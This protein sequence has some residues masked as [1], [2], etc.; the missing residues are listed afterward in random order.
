M[1]ISF[2][3][4]TPKRISATNFV[5][6]GAEMAA[7][8]LGDALALRGH[9]VHYY[10]NCEVSDQ[11]HEYAEFFVAE[12]DRIIAVRASDALFR[13]V[14]C[15]RIVLWSGDAYDQ[16]NN[17]LLN[18][19]M[20]VN[21]LHKVV[22]KSQWQLVSNLEHFPVLAESGKAITM[23]NGV[24]PAHYFA[25][26]TTETQTGFICTS[27]IF[28]GVDRF[29]HIWPEIYK[30]FGMELNLYANISGLYD[31]APERDAAYKREFAALREL[32][33]LNI[34]ATLPQTD[35]IAE[36][37]KHYLMLYPNSDFMESS[38]NSALE[39]MCAGTPVITTEKAGLPETIKL[40]FGKLIPDNL[41]LTEYTKRMIAHIKWFLDND[42]RYSDWNTKRRWKLIDKFAWSKVAE[43]WESEVLS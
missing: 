28:R 10:G 27:R 19:I 26:E 39:S 9:D 7:K 30:E 33:G 31:D 25:P 42:K 24:N 21:R 40:G 36:M 15:E 22:F 6:G 16:P 38:C 2:F 35:I 32:N 37:H 14:K 20:V 5:A 41:P 13:P 4:A 34:K 11:F 23:P 12:H 43:Q 1:R 3:F 17:Y 18:A 8:G 29:V